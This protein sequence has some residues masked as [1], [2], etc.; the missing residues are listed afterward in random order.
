MIE[1]KLIAA[2]IKDKL[3]VNVYDNSRRQNIVDARSLFCYI[4]RKDFNLTLYKIVDIFR[5]NGKSFSHCSVLHN[6]EIYD[7][8]RKWDHRLEEIRNKV[9]KISNPQAILINRIRDI[10]DNDRL[11]GLHNLIDFQEQQLK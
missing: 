4:L 8:A 2:E 5:A 10:H 1:Y 3:G 7:I 9:L 11:Q 6:V